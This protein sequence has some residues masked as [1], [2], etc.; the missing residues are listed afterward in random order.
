MT[1][2]GISSIRNKFYTVAES[3]QIQ[4][5]LKGNDTNKNGKCGPLSLLL[6]CE[7]SH[8]P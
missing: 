4:M 2:T 6:R 5:Y 1:W 7:G 8:K 3:L